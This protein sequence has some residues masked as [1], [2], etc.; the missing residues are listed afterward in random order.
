MKILLGTLIL[1]FTLCSCDSE[2][3]KNDSS[4]KDVN[5]I[6][7]KIINIPE[8][9]LTVVLFEECEYIIFKEEKDSNTSYGFMAHKGNCKNPI[10]NC[11]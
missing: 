5:S 2:L 4:S 3:R 9:E 6:E 7:S 10:H 8:H 1:L 11:K